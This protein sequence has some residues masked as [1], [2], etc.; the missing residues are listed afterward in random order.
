[1]KEIYY[2]RSDFGRKA[3]KMLQTRP[4]AN[5]SYFLSES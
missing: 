3:E 5:L 2:I 1:M 4:N